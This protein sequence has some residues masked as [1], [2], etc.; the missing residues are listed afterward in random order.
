M[1][2]LLLVGADMTFSDEEDE[3]PQ[4]EATTDGAHQKP[5]PV[6]LPAASLAS[7]PATLSVMLRTG[8]EIGSSSNIVGDERSSPKSVASLLGPI[9]FIEHPDKT[10]NFNNSKSILYL[11]CSCSDSSVTISEVARRNATTDAAN[12][13]EDRQF[14]MLEPLRRGSNKRLLR[15]ENLHYHSHGMKSYK[16]KSESDIDHV[17]LGRNR[18]NSVSN[19]STSLMVKTNC[20]IDYVVLSDSSL[21]GCKTDD[22]VNLTNAF[23]LLGNCKN[24]HIH[25]R[26]VSPCRLGWA[27]SS[28]QLPAL[29]HYKSSNRSDTNLSQSHYS[30]ASYNY[31]TPQWLSV[32]STHSSYSSLS[33]TCPSR[34]LDGNNKSDISDYDYE[35]HIEI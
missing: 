32:M 16:S 27:S 28:E 8:G 4:P 23:T 13:Q 30:M 29:K 31:N 34:I 7:L 15:L 20:Q 19:G 5:S 1:N 26:G 35:D 18:E 11:P 14:Q 9:L 10:G 6:L 2:P 25:E 24:N 33:T 12:E 17:N 3:L 21:P 22:N